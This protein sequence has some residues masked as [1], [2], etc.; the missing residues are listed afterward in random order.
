MLGAR[1]RGFHDARYH[2]RICVFRIQIDFHDKDNCDL[3][4]LDTPGSL[5]HCDLV[6]GEYQ[7]GRFRVTGAVGAERMLDLERRPIFRGVPANA[8]EA[9][10]ILHL[11]GPCSYHLEHRGTGE[12][13]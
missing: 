6:R 13:P 3:Q 4:H 12:E 5:D 2:G 9:A 10:S 7:V 11:F 1:D 8:P